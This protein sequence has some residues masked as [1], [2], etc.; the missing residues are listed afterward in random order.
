MTRR[1][2]LLSSTIAAFL[3]TSCKQDG[4]AMADEVCECVAEA[5]QLQK[6]VRRMEA[7]EECYSLMES[8][9]KQLEENPVEKKKFDD[10]LPCNVVIK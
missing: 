5:N 10:L 4:T 1:N 6:G 3:L 7:F 9:S 8:Y 2:I